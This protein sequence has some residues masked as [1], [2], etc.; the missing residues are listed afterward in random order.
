[1]EDNGASAQRVALS[2]D[3]RFARHV[4]SGQSLEQAHH[5]TCIGD[6]ICLSIPL[7][8]SLV[9]HAGENE[10]A[11]SRLLSLLLRQD[12]LCQSWLATCKL[13]G[14]LSAGPG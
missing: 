7:D 10:W 1:M 11:G 3:E 12:E 9:T 13:V 2:N 14:Q 6:G 5:T 4:R 8:Q